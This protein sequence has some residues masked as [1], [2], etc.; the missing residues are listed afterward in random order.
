[1][2]PDLFYLHA[3][4]PWHIALPNTPS[5]PTAA[6]N[7]KQYCLVLG[8]GKWGVGAALAVWANSCLF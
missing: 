6:G 2:L 7:V 3:G 4:S 5:S 8:A 1:M